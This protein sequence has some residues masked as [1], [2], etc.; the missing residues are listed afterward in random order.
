MVYKI[1]K[2]F[3]AYLLFRLSAGI[4]TDP[5]QWPSV[6]DLPYCVDNVFQGCLYGCAYQSL[7]SAG[8]IPCGVDCGDWSCACQDYG[9]AYSVLTS[10]ASYQCS[11]NLYAVA[12]ITSIF[13][14]FCLQ[15]TATPTE[16]TG[17]TSNP[18][19]SEPTGILDC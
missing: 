16:P 12:S 7:P 11:T 3:I 8:C 9:P 14:S 2:F 1:T 19:Q 13:N 15:L 6:T 18:A 4:I 5:Q 17:P 10:V